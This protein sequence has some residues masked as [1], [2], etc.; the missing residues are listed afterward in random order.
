M[1]IGP[2]VAVFATVAITADIAPLRNGRSLVNAED[3]YGKQNFTV[4]I[5]SHFS[6]Q[7]DRIH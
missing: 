1:K 7:N 3:T 4:M 2:V 5:L 6:S